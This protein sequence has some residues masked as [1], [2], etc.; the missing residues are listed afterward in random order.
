[1]GDIVSRKVFDHLLDHMLEIHRK[2]LNIISAYTHDYDSYVCKLNFLNSYIKGIE[3]FLG[4]CIGGKS[5]Q[6]VAVCDT[7]QHR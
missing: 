7:R 1:M 5:K 6:R 3:A 4:R 2:K